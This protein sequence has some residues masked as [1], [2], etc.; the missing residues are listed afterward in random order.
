M[1]G[2]WLGLWKKEI[3]KNTLCGWPLVKVRA[4][5]KKDILCGWP[6]VRVR[7]KTEK[8]PFIVGLSLGLGQKREEH[9]LW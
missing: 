8:T 1:V 7:A 3:E 6:L 5:I 2:L 4:K 9:T